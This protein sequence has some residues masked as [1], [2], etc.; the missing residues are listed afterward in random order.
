MKIGL[1][2]KD[3]KI[4]KQNK[5][6]TLI[7]NS[8]LERLVVSKTILHPKRIPTVIIMLVRRRCITL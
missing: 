7:D 4:I 6:Y 2:E 5:T 1:N 3:S 8:K